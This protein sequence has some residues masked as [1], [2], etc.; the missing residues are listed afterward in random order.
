MVIFYYSLNT[1]LYKKGFFRSLCVIKSCSS[2]KVKTKPYGHLATK[3]V[4]YIAFNQSG[5]KTVCEAVSEL[6]VST[7]TAKQGKDKTR[8]DQVQLH[9]LLLISLSVVE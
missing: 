5:S 4:C 7:G 8:S 2:Q 6:T 9:P 1:V 3:T